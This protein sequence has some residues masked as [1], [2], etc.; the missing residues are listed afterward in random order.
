M[1]NKPLEGI[2][3]IEM[4]TYV[5][6][7]TAAR[8]MADWGAEVIK[9]EAPR[10]DFYRTTAGHF[11][12]LPCKEDFN[13]LFQPMNANKR[14]ICIDLKTLEGKDAFMKLI[15]TADIF[16]T[17]TRPKPL[18]KLGIGYDVLK[19]KFP[20]LICGYVSGFGEKGPDKDRAGFDVAAF[21]ARGGALVDWAVSESTPSK[22]FPGFGDTAVS[23]TLLSGVLA[24]LYHREK[25]GLGDEINVSLFG[26]ALY[27]N[28]AGVLTGQPQFGHKYPKSRYAQSDPMAPLYK[29]QDGDWLLITETNWNTKYPTLLKLIGKEEYIDDPRFASLDATREHME[30]VVRIIEDGFAHTNTDVALAGL[31]AMDTV[32]E[33]LASPED[34][35]KDKQA[36]A[37]G[38]LREVTFPTGDKVIYPN[39]PIQFRSMD[40]YE[41]K[42]APG[43][44]EH[45][46]EILQELGY[47]KENIEDMANKKAII[48]K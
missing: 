26:T 33:K 1:S 47:S 31:V 15:G 45:T 19:K 34:L 4:G 42:L 5:A 48:I 17:N 44:G 6:V 39:N 41:Y 11:F 28:V 36:W 38:Y 3:V 9:V 2:R 25:T 14:D 20:K 27:Y 7:P 43:H 16:L 24:A 13:V 8:M 46:S 35:Y 32:N 12:Q 10:G 21:W 23:N 22:P 30:A 18:Q 40:S 29:T 37:N